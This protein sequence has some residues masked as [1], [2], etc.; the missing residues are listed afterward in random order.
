MKKNIQ[1]RINARESIVGQS[2]SLMPHS[3]WQTTS[4]AQTVGQ[5]ILA[6]AG[7]QPA[8]AEPE[9]SRM[10]LEKPAERRLRARSPA[11][12]FMPQT[13]KG[14]TM[15]HWAVSLRAVWCRAGHP[16]G[17]L[18]APARGRAKT[19]FESVSGGAFAAKGVFS[20]AAS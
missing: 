11:P 7:F 12:Q 1:P 10:G 4:S 14:K 13:Q 18:K 2:V 19:A 9:D 6:A 16:P 20:C 5:P 3:F 17:P 8:L 15:W